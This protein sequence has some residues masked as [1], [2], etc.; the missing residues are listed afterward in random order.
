MADD[1]M[2]DSGSADA[3]SSDV[4]PVDAGTGDSSAP[5]AS[6]EGGLSDADCTGGKYYQFAVGAYCGSGSCATAQFICADI[7]LPVCSCTG[8]TYDNECSAGSAGVNIMSSDRC[9]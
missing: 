5:D 7:Y 9:P 8:V 6:S 1:S 4:G 3:G 2:A